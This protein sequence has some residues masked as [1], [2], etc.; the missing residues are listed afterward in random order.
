MPSKNGRSELSVG[1]IHSM[2]ELSPLVNDVG[3]QDL[4]QAC[5]A[6]ESG[7]GGLVLLTKGS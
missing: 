3:L 1:I 2:F 4:V 5:N 7:S 6:R